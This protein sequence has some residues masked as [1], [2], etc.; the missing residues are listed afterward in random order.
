MFYAVTDLL[1]IA[2]IMDMGHCNSTH[3]CQPNPTQP[4]M[5]PSKFNPTQPMG[6]PNP[7]PCLFQ[8]S[9]PAAA[10]VLSPKLFLLLQVPPTQWRSS[11]RR[12]ST[13]LVMDSKPR[14]SIA[15][16]R[17]TSTLDG[18]GRRVT[19]KFRSDVRVSCDAE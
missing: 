17:S 16:R 4:I 18:T 6:G 8:T 13:R 7:R 9:G 14:R 19:S 10:K 15:V 5:C 12:T 2:T 1:T 3:L 11:T